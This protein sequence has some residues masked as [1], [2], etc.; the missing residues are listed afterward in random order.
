MPRGGSYVS[1]MSPDQNDLTIIFETIVSLKIIYEIIVS[2]MIIYETIVSL[3]RI[4]DN[5]GIVAFYYDEFYF[6]FSLK[7]KFFNCHSVI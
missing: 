2:L 3:T 5:A 1:L 6:N 7:I 4:N